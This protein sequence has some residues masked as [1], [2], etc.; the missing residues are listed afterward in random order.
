VYLF[1]SF[2]KKKDFLKHHLWQ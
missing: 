2:E 1:I